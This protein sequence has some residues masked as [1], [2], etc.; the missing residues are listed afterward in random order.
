M[1]H[2][3]MHESVQ[4]L[5]VDMSEVRS[6]YRLVPALVGRLTDKPTVVHVPCPDWCTVDHLAQR[7][8][9]LEDI[10]HQG[11]PAALTITT[12]HPARV[13]LEVY[14]SWWPS[15]DGISEKPCLSV[16]LDTEVE[17]YDRTAALAMADQLVAFAANVRRLA[18]SLPDDNG[19]SSQAD[20]ALRRVRQG[21]RA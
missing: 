7:A 14:L 20:E 21:G 15:S 5:A 10:N 9:F 3:A 12:L 16:D 8:V 17:V 11:E 6:G 13:P 19:D 1:A 2:S 18:E 4:S